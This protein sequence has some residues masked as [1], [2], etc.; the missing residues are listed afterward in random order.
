MAGPDHEIF[1]V[2][3]VTEKLRQL[4]FKETIKIIFLKKKKIQGTPLNKKPTRKT[5][6]LQKSEC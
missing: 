6:K 1:V 4:T 3:L 2:A 5:Y